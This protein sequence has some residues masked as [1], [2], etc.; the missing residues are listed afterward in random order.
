MRYVLSLILLPSLV[1]IA[2]CTG[3]T[4]A[5][6]DNRVPVKFQIRHADPWAVK[7]MIEGSA[8]TQPELSTL[9]GV[10]GGSNNQG[11]NNT[12]NQNSPNLKD[13]FLVVNPTDNS[14]WWYPKK[15]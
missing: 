1:S 9:L 13:G 5:Q 2:L 14:L 12:Q 3:G 4:K 6:I 10:R 15:G 7:A 11:G 8:I